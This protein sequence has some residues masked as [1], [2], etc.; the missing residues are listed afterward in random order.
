[1]DVRWLSKADVEAVGLRPEECLELVRRTLEWHAQGL[2]EMPPKL[3]V[4]PPDGRHMHAMPAF[5]QPFGALGVKW[6]GDYPGNKR[7]GL[8]TLSAV[9][10]LSDPHSGSPLSIMEGTAVTAMRTAAM[11]GVSLQAC[12]KQD[13]EV[14]VII[15]T[16]VQARVHAIA[17]PK[18]L[19]QLKTIVVVGRDEAAATHFCQLVEPLSEAKV[20]PAPSREE[21][22]RDALVVITLTNAVTTRLLEPEWLMPGVTLVVLDNGGKE[23]GILSY[24]DRVIVDDRRPFGSEEVRHRFPTGVPPIEGEIGKI[25]IGELPGRRNEQERIL[26]LNLGVAAADIAVAAEVYRRASESG[27]GTTMSL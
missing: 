20:L 7:R 2:V 8:P 4:H 15:G 26:I 12:A 18:T 23:T 1:M 21:A 9:I 27:V 13:V 25:L 24:V 14:A 11:T 3:G 22:V 16:G 17:L 5:I 6:L 10:I 19:P